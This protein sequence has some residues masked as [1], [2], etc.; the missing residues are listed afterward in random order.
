M[1][2]RT[3]M[4]PLDQSEPQKTCQSY[5]ELILTKNGN[6]RL[7]FY[8]DNHTIIIIFTVISVSLPQLQDPLQLFHLFILTK[9]RRSA[10]KT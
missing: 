7:H 3:A 9:K 6:D 8:R 5:Q 2:E 10:I 1:N 4:Q